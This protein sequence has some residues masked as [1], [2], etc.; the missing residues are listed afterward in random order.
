MFESA[1]GFRINLVSNL[2]LITEK[3]EIIALAAI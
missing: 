2:N 1:Q 3:L